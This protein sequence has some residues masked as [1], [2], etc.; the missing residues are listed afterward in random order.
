MR[1]RHEP[2]DVLNKADACYKTDVFRGCGYR[3]QLGHNPH[4]PIPAR[5]LCNLKKAL[6]RF[7]G[8]KTQ[9]ADPTP[10]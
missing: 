6:S 9:N 7:S 1:F 8:V 3:Q 5:H 2:K 4:S 10:P